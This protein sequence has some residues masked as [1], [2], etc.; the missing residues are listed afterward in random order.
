M[1]VKLTEKYVSSFLTDSDIN[2]YSEKIKQEAA[3]GAKPRRKPPFP[4]RIRR[5]MER[6]A[7]SQPGTVPK[8]DLYARETTGSC[9]TNRKEP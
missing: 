1:S 9:R 5:L 2:S 4:E 8:S 7:V 3:A 6:R